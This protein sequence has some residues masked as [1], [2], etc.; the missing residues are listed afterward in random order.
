M[1]RDK[2]PKKKKKLKLWHIILAVFIIGALAPRSQD[3]DVTESAIPTEHLATQVILQDPARESPPEPTFEMFFDASRFITDTSTTLTEAQLIE[4]LGEPDATEE[5][6]YTLPATPVP[7][8]S[9]HYEPNENSFYGHTYSYHFNEG[10]LQRLSINGVQVPYARKS[11]IL[12]LFGLE[13][14]SNTVVAGDTGVA[15][16]VEYCG[17]RQL[18]VQVMDERALQT[19]VI[20]Y[21]DVFLK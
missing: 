19:I 4:I 12:A 8:K 16:R 18:W 21:G 6:N 2:K 5:W 1:K 7:I 20:D 9:L 17:V 15:Y 10:T 11:D 14:N 3:E 13:R